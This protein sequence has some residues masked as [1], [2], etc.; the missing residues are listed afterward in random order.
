MI[1]AVAV[2]GYVS[3][4]LVALLSQ[5]N[6]VFVVDI[7]LEKVGTINTGKARSRMIILRKIYRN[8]S[9]EDLI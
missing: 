2:M 3:L 4:I 9:R 6:H 7:I 5:N 1:I 8:M